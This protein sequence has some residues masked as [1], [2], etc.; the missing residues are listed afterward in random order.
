MAEKA[1]KTPAI[2]LFLESVRQLLTKSLWK[3]RTYFPFLNHSHSNNIQ[4][5]AVK[6]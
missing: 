6:Y 4:I 1:S 5:M 3:N 2:D